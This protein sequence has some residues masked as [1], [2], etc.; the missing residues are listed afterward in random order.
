[1]IKPNVFIIIKPKET[2]RDPPTVP[3]A[4]G[5]VLSRITKE[6]VASR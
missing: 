4:A 3:H 2:C 6:G 1:M 5:A